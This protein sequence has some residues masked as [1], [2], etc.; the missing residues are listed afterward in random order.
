MW[1]HKHQCCIL[2]RHVHNIIKLWNLNILVHGLPGSGKKKTIEQVIKHFCKSFK[3][4]FYFKEFDLYIDTS[5]KKVSQE[6]FFRQ[7][8]HIYEFHLQSS[9]MDRQII[10][11]VINNFANKYYICNK[12][13]INK[14]MILY[15]VECLS[16]EA[17]VI[18]NTIISKNVRTSRF[19]LITSKLCRVSQKIRGACALYKINRPSEQDMLTMLKDICQKENANITQE[20]LQAICKKHDCNIYE[21]VTEVQFDELGIQKSR[22]FVF[23]RIIEK[24]LNNASLSSLRS[25]IYLLLINNL[26]SNNIICI[27]CHG[28]LKQRNFDI[29]MI[30]HILHISCIYEARTYAEERALYHIEAFVYKILV[31]LHDKTVSYD[32][33]RS[34]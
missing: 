13:P 4:Q 29:H 5:N 21:C 14:I 8:E 11:D 26:S 12:T 9:N 34:V 31:L 7:N 1:A 24:L 30:Q 3:P 16:E 20:R 27:L 6:L 25:D 22:D 17:S 19:V 33:C 18:L 32:W 10:R 23:D 2:E 15:N 28:L